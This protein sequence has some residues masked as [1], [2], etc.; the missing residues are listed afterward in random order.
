MRRR[1]NKEKTTEPPTCVDLL[2]RTGLPVVYT[3]AS[4][5]INEIENGKTTDAACP[6][7]GNIKEFLIL[8]EDY[9]RSR[10]S[11]CLTTI[12]LSLAQVKH[13]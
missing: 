7:Q 1:L 6:Y 4:I 12:H 13:G 11:Y 3:I 5:E 8:N 2:P 9:T 10:R